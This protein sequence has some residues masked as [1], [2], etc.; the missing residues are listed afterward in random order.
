MKTLFVSMII[1]VLLMVFLPLPV[2]E[3]QVTV[4]CGDVIDGE[5]L[6]DGEAH[7]YHLEMQEGDRF[8]VYADV[9]EKDYIDLRVDVGIIAPS[10]QVIDGFASVRGRGEN[11]VSTAETRELPETG[12][13]TIELRA[14]TS[15]GGEYRLY[16]GCIRSDGEVVGSGNQFV[17]AQ[18][19]SIFESRFEA[20]GGRHRYYVNLV[21]GDAVNI[22]AETLNTSYE[23]LRIDVGIISPS[24]RVID[25]FA[26]VRGRGE[27]PVSTAETRELPE[28]GTY[29][30][31]L[32]AY[33][34]T[35]G[36]YNFFIGC[37]LA[38]GVVI[39]PGD[40]LPDSTPTPPPVSANTTFSGFGFPGL[41]PVDFSE[42][43]TV[44]FT[45]GSPNT[46]SI[47]AG[48]EGIF[49]FLFTGNQG[50]TMRLDFTRVSGNLNLGLAVL[51]ADNQVAFQASLVTSN[52]LSTDFVL[53]VTGD[54]T[55]GVFPIDLI[56]PDAPEATTF[57]ITGT[58]NP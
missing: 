6:N 41:S 5:F 9:I 57:Q 32:R 25:G 13:Y 49:G 42:G 50:D 48:Y 3:A 17:P 26:S 35:G 8:I 46:G 43:V 2:I 39:E 53:P 27:R 23:D 47:S 45:M 58:L 56:P 12:T 21:R 24:E 1:C 4:Q 16:I 20:D 15:T 52:S 40:V 11:P 29:T 38:D 36:D 10:G 7:T 19:G 14:Y 44:P 37:T 22:L 18:C 28:T 30:I 34:S 31:E 33:T 54:Y 55:I 51:S